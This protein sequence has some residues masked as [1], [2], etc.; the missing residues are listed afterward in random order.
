MCGP[1]TTGRSLLV[2]F[3]A[4]CFGIGT[5]VAINGIFIQLPLLVNEAPEGWS[6]PSFL[7]VMVQIGN[8]GPIAYTLLQKCLRS[9]RRDPNLIYVLLGIG[10]TSTLLI[11]F[12]YNQTAFVAGQEHSV[13]LFI[14][15]MFTAFHACS[16]SVLFMPYMGRFREVYL[17][18]YFIGEGLSGL[19]PSVVALIQ[20]VGGKTECILVND[21]ITG[22][23]IYEKF[24]PPPQFS[25][26]TFFLIV[27]GMLVLSCIGFTLLDNLSAAKK[28]YADVT[29]TNGNSYSYSNNNSQTSDQQPLKNVNT[30]LSKNIYWF[31]LFL[32]GIVCFFSNGVLVSIQS[33]SCLPYG[34][35]AYHLSATLSVIA[36]PVACFLAIFLPKASVRCIAILSSIAGVLTLY[37][38]I[39]AAMSPTPFLYDSTVGVVLVIAAWTLLNGLVSYIKLAITTVMRSQGGKS[40]LWTGGSQQFGSAVG[41]IIIFILINITKSFQSAPE[42]SCEK[43][44]DIL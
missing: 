30:A 10:T 26:Q 14:L 22:E 24:T 2:D 40:L 21:T 29:I 16:S 5:W 28:E 25:S 15:T 4:I 13:A 20:G 9:S 43:P 27:F 1:S 33:Y 12:F 37:V 41:S 6:L 34:T 44:N 38:V 7:S 11:A 32:I 8:F 42:I 19:L 39:T 23:Q 3:L 17:I 18:T 36:N 31:L 35:E